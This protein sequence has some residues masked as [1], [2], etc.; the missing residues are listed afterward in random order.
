[1]QKLEKCRDDKAAGAAELVPGFL[2]LIKQELACPL[3]TLFQS[4]LA[5]ESVAADWKMANVVPVYKGGSRNM[6]TNYRQISLTS[7]LCKVFETIVRDQ[8]IEFAASNELI[9]NSQH[10]FRKGSSYLSNLLLF[11]DKVLRSVN[12]GYSVDVVFPDL[13]KAFDKVPYKR[14]MEKFKN[15]V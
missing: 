13:A 5:S 7:H 12:E 8:V 6:S 9:R 10:W 3:T 14:F 1:L 4:I 15:M 11:L 2:N